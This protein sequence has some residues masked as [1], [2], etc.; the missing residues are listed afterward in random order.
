[1]GNLDIGGFISADLE[2]QKCDPEH[3]VNATED[4]PRLGRAHQPATATRIPGVMLLSPD[5]T[6]KQIP[7]QV[8]SV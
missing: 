2:K 5:F 3:T 8:N 7:A 6:V 4:G 1:M